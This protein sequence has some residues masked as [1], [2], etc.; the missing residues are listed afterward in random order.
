[1]ER[2]DGRT[3][4]VKK[5]GEK[6]ISEGRSRGMRKWE[7]GKDRIRRLK[8]RQREMEGQEERREEKGELERRG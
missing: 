6:L 2:E 7:K 5:R 3:G 1:M 4:G 8:V